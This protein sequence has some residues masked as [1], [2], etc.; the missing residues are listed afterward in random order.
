MHKK[1]IFYNGQIHTDAASEVKAQAM[2]V[3]NGHIERIGSDLEVLAD[4]D[5]D[6]LLV[7]LRGKCVLSGFQDSHCHILST[8]L[9]S[10]HLDLHG[11]TSVGEIIERGKKYIKEHEIPEGTWVWG[12]GFD[13]HL[14]QSPEEAKQ[15][16]DGSVAEA[17]SDK[18]PVLLERICGHIASANRLALNAV[19]YDENTHITGGALD[20][21]VSGRLT[22]VMREAA[23]DFFKTRIPAPSVAELKNALCRMMKELNALGITGVHSDDVTGAPIAQVIQAFQELEAEGKMT[24]RV[25]EEV[26]AARIAVLNDFL[27]YNLRS[28]DGSDFFRIGNIKL[29]TDGS[30]GAGTAYLREDYSDEPGNRGIAVYTQEELNEVVA[31]AHLAGMQIACHAIGDG[32]A[33]ECIEAF[34]YANEQ[35]RVTGAEITN[36]ICRRVPYRIVHC[37]FADDEMMRRMREERVAADIQPPFVASDYE[38]AERRMGERVSY[39]YVWKTLLKEGILIAG[40]SDSPVE[41]FD[42]LWGIQTA[43]CRTDVAGNPKGGWH[44]EEGLTVEEAV[45]L[46]T[47]APARIAGL[48]KSQ[49][50]LEE[51]KLADFVV[52]SEDIFKK[53]PQS[54]SELEVEMT[55]VGGRIVYSRA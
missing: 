12:E 46:Y 8:G 51:G 14:F 19:G 53:A 54:I 16:P 41:S 48:D 20:K 3:E 25:F 27:K 18:H 35:E 33:L 43:V 45:A 5:E 44:K 2:R 1:T 6:T 37:Q 28:G 47:L 17:I 15:V 10:L 50:T 52:L 34:A 40:G 36:E 39:G 9:G 42:P 22:G 49:G 4:R 38:L 26:Q 23:L 7:D 32:A 29:L 31:A 24:L 11:V 55:V 30:L 13:H 21:D